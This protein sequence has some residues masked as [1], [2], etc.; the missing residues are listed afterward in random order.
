MKIRYE[1]EDGVVSGYGDEGKAAVMEYESDPLAKYFLPWKVSP[2]SQMITNSTGVPVP[3]HLMTPIARFFSAA[4][5]LVQAT[6]RQADIS[7]HNDWRERKPGV[8]YYDA[9]IKLEAALKEAING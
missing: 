6:V 4:A 5:P 7:W 1:S 3:G 8:F 2:V 9:L